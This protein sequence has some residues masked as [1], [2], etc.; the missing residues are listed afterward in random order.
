MILPPFSLERTLKLLHG[1]LGVFILPWV[2]VI[3]L[4]G[5]SLNHWNLIRGWVTPPS[6][7]EALFGVVRQS[8]TRLKV[9]RSHKPMKRSFGTAL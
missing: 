7:D 1:W 4:T 6:Y 9:P 2:V 8:L 3:G 5:L